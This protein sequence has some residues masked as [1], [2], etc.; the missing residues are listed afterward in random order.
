MVTGSTC[1]HRNVAP[2]RC[3][4]FSTKENRH[5]Q[6]LSDRSLRRALRGGG[7]SLGVTEQLAR[8][9]VESPSDFM[10]APLIESAKAKILDTLATS[11]AGS[12]A[13]A[14]TISLETVRQS[15]GRPEAT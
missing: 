15:G 6:P 14:T 7:G 4:V 3:V 10:T 11:L 2:A 5:L 13:P 8:F 12:R 1:S 9:A